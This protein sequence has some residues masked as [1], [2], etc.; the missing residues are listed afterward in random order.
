[1]IHPRFTGASFAFFPAQAVA[2]TLEDFVVDVA[3]KVGVRGGRWTRVLGYV[4]TAA[5]LTYSV[6]WFADNAARSGMTQDHLPFQSHV[7]R[8]L[9]GTIG[10]ATG[11]DV[12]R[13]MAA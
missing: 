3:R 12:V 1:M 5:W 8:P 7:V 11:I 9:M 10:N 4:W 2:I 6:A 13:W